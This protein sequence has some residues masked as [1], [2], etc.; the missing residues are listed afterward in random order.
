[1][2]SLGQSKI[3]LHVTWY[4]S[5]VIIRASQ[6]CE[7]TVSILIHDHNDC[8]SFRA[9]CVG[10]HARFFKHLS[11]TIHKNTDEAVIFLTK[12]EMALENLNNLH[13]VTHVEKVGFKFG[14][15]TF[16]TLRSLN[17]FQNWLSVGVTGPPKKMLYFPFIILS[18]ALHVGFMDIF[19][20]K[21]TQN[22]FF[23]KDPEKIQ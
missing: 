14:S 22:F 23:L 17:V 16:Q 3:S 5:F 19:I 4:W 13:R 20:L 12:K 6:E 1:M 15:S 10:Q 18:V 11:L 8:L 21:Q 7:I 2:F 9:Y